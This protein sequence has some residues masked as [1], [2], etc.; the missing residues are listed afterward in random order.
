MYKFSERDI[1]ISTKLD[2]TYKTKRLKNQRNS[3]LTIELRK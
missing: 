2:T 3:M 1:T